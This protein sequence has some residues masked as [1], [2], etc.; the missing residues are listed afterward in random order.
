VPVCLKC[1]TAY[2][3]DEDH[4][5][6]SR[7]SAWIVLCCAAVGSIVGSLA[8][9]VSLPICCFSI[10]LFSS[11]RA[12]RCYLMITSVPVFVACG[13]IVGTALGARFGNTVEN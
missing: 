6:V 1:D 12:D 7:S 4:V 11:M 8:G 13:F 5:C 10:G 3:D 9:Y 2:L